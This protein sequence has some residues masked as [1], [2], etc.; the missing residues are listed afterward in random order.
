MTPVVPSLPSPFPSRYRE[1]TSP[2]P[3]AAHTTPHRDVRVGSPLVT[4]LFLEAE[5]S[6]AWI[7]ATMRPWVAR[8]SPPFPE[9]QTIP[10]AESVS[11]ILWRGRNRELKLSFLEPHV[12]SR[13]FHPEGEKAILSS[14][15]HISTTATKYLTSSERS[16]HTR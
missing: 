5:E 6:S 11:L 12:S 13:K 10:R 1:L 15:A 7:L 16:L 14:V 2:E 3:P 8:N 4:W 9:L